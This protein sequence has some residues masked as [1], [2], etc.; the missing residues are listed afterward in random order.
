M[1]KREKQ[2]KRQEKIEQRIKDDKRLEKVRQNSDTGK[3]GDDMAVSDPVTDSSISSDTDMEEEER[4]ARELGAG[5]QP[6][7]SKMTNCT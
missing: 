7:Q 3:L 1:S 4:R 6:Q 5:L 2:E